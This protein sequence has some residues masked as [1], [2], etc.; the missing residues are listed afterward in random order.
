MWI[1]AEKSESK[2]LFYQ[3]DCTYLTSGAHRC[4]R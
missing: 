3:L 1:S 2:I 4:L